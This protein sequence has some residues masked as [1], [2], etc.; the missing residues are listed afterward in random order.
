MIGYSVAAPF[1]GRGLARSLLSRALAALAREHRGAAVI[2][3]VKRENVASLRVF[4]ALGFSRRE[5]DHAVEYRRTASPD[6]EPAD[7]P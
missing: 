6:R 2:A 1:R 3:E 4:E 7:E 5:R